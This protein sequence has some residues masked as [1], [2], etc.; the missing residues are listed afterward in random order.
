M[1]SATWPIIEAG[2]GEAVGSEEA[3]AEGMLVGI[4]VTSR[5]V[6]G[7]AVGEACSRPKA[8]QAWAAAA[9]AAVAPRVRRKWRRE[10]RD[11]LLNGSACCP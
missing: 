2:V 4:G 7:E 6:V 9:A 3:E 8:R 1:T 11:W 5:G 10:R